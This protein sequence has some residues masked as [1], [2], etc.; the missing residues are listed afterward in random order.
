MDRKAQRRLAR[1]DE[2]RANIKSYELSIK[3]YKE[4]LDELLHED[5]NANGDPL[6]LRR[7]RVLGTTFF[8]TCLGKKLRGKSWSYMVSDEETNEINWY[9]GDK[10]E[11]VPEKW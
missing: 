4:E 1:I 6:L 5:T 10:L 8:G 9:K 7:V 11:V 3:L 2:L